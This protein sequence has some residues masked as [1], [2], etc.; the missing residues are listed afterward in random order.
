MVSR[1]F[2]FYETIG[3]IVLMFFGMVLGV[4]SLS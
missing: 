3:S 4:A 1:G 2:G